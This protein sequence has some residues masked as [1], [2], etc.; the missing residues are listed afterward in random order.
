[1]HLDQVGYQGDQSAL[2]SNLSRLVANDPSAAKL[3]TLFIDRKIPLFRG[4]FPDEWVQKI[5]SPTGYAIFEPLNH[6]QKLAILK[7]LLSR[8]YCLIEGLPG[9]GKTSLIVA[10]IRFAVFAGLSVLLTSFT[11]SAVDNVLVKLLKKGCD[12]FVRLGHQHRIHPSILPFSAE[13]KSHQCQTIDQV[14]LIYRLS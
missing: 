14:E 13:I 9:T 2:Y 10:L 3:R 11:H 1:M 7:V 6:L 5:Q 12:S 4:G 8:Q